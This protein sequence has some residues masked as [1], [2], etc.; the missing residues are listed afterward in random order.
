MGI[1]KQDI[2]SR[3]RRSTESYE[4]NAT[5][6]KQIVQHLAEL[7]VVYVPQAS[8]TLEIGCGTGLL[9]EKIG[10]IWRDNHLY[11]NDLV[12]EMCDKTLSRCHLPATRVIRGDI[13]QVVLSETFDLIVSASTFQWL[14]NPLATFA[15]LAAQLLP[16]GWLV[17]STFGKDNF[18]ELRSV[19]GQGLEYRSVAELQTL[20]PSEL[21]VVYSEETC[22]VLTFKDP[23]E[24]LRHVKKTGVNA[25]DTNVVWT[26][27]RMQTFAETYKMRF[28]QGGTCPLTYHPIYM[29]CRKKERL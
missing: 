2:A 27:G 21:E 11:I 14:A 25:T 7:L 24:I 20:L 5:V 28:Q 29:V 15:K 22:Q 1:D 26:R 13:E 23:L 17:F 6:Q 18:K 10:R 9:S 16:G 19:T 12:G 8:R 4:A 3:F